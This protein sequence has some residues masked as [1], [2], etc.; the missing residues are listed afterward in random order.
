MEYPSNFGHRVICCYTHFLVFFSPRMFCCGSRL[1]SPLGFG[2]DLRHIVLD[3]ITNRLGLC[4]SG[5]FDCW[6]ASWLCSFPC[7]DTNCLH[8]VC[9]SY[10]ADGPA[11]VYVLVVG[12]NM[13]IHVMVITSWDGILCSCISIHL[14]G[15]VLRFSFGWLLSGSY[16]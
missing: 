1:L 9:S 4:I 7:F 8:S 2:S 15:T 12:T 13:Y 5:V 11:R 3:T 6:H 16:F 10:R 14:S